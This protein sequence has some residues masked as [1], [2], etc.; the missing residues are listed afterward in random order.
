MLINMFISVMLKGER[1]YMPTNAQAH[2]FCTS[3]NSNIC[4]E[5]IDDCF[6]EGDLFVNYFFEG[7]QLKLS[8]RR[9]LKAHILD[10][11]HEEE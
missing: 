9:T 7:D 5:A 4:Q 2:T 6:F 1:S 10:Y 3:F 8:S 11:Q